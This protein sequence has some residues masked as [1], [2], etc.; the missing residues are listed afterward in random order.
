VGHYAGAYSTGN[1]NV[2][3]GNEAG[4]NFSTGLGNVI[5]GSKAAGSLSGT[6]TAVNNNTIVGFFSY[7]A[8][9]TSQ[10]GIASLGYQTGFLA[11]GNNGTILGFQ[12]GYNTGATP[13]TANALTTGADNTFIGANAG[14]G[15]TT[16][17][18]NATAIGSQA[19]VDADNTVVLGDENVTDVFA[20]SD[21]GADI[22]AAAVKEASGA[23]ELAMTGTLASLTHTDGAGDYS[24]SYNYSGNAKYVVFDSGNSINVFAQMSDASLL[25]NATTGDSNAS[26]VTMTGTTIDFEGDLDNSGNGVITFKTAN[27]ATTL[28]LNSAGSTFVNEIIVPVGSASV[29]SITF[30]ADLDTGIFSEAAGEVNLASNTFETAE[31]KRENTQIK[32]DE[33]SGDEYASITLN[34]L[35]LGLGKVELL[36]QDTATSATFTVDGINENIETDVT[37]HGP[38]GTVLAP[39]FSFT[40]NP[41]MGIYAQGTAVAFSIDNNLEAQFDAGGLYLDDGGEIEFEGATADT[42]HTTLAVEDPTGVNTVTIPDE[43]GEISTIQAGISTLTESSATNILSFP[44]ASS[45]TDFIAGTVVVVTECTDT[46]NTIYRHDTID[47]ICKNISDTE[48]CAFQSNLGSA[49]DLVEGTASYSAHTVAADSS[50]TNTVEFTLNATCSL[51]QTVLQTSWEIEFHHPDWELVTE[52]N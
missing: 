5:I 16:Q 52:L 14:L 23:E 7:N 39:T 41:D 50:A 9:A 21:G 49:L 36:S 31:F 45:V 2:F 37:Y 11:T 26:T 12:A 30:P 25:L 42:N 8:L 35:G 28:T 51:T 3:L 27:D 40:S 20:S 34:A 43:S 29:P 48:A 19:Y 15:S 33:V 38:N 6:Q 17:R 47:F 22:T 44:L 18:S 4:Q 13:T 10:T 24:A 1:D 32:V 46:T